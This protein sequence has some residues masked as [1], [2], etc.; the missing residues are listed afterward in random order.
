MS[1]P[2]PVAAYEST[3]TEILSDRN[4]LFAAAVGACECWGE[5]PRCP[6]CGGHG[7]AG[8][9]TPDARLYAEFVEPAVQKSTQPKP[10]GESPPIQGAPQ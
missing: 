3:A 2:A 7:S 4:V 6:D 1:E 5:D 9:S 8:W 10:A